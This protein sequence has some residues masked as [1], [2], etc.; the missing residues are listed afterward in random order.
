M[1]TVLHKKG[2]SLKEPVWEMP[3]RSGVGRVPAGGELG[4][5]APHGTL[6]ATAF[7]WL[8]YMAGLTSTSKGCSPKPLGPELLSR[9]D[10]MADAHVASSSRRAG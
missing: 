1:M 5:P 7:F 3:G 6:G 4:P 8:R 2:Y 9:R 10:W